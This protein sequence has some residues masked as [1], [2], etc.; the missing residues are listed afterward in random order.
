M[1]FMDRQPLTTEA[2]RLDADR[3]RLTV[4]GD[5]DFDTAPGLVAAAAALRAAG[6]L[7]LVLDLSGV[8]RCDASGLS[9]FVEIFRS[10][11]P[12]SLRLTGVGAE[13]QRLLDRTGLAEVLATAATD[14][15]R[16]VG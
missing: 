8:V 4:A 1:E 7:H 13:V 12:G 3:A 15:L 10:G 5:L 11:R 9:A 16:D 6:H 14:D 2:F